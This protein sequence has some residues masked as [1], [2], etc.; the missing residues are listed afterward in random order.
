MAVMFYYATVSQMIEGKPLQG[1]C[2]A[3]IVKTTGNC[4]QQNSVT[5]SFVCTLSLPDMFYH[6]PRRAAYK[7]TSGAI[8]SYT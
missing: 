2:R 8:C 1:I 3:I 7:F 6:A 5:S 4:Q